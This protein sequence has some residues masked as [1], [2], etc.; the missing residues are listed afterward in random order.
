[1]NVSQ[2]AT[3]FPD[4]TAFA[5]NAV[6]FMAA[7]AAIIAGAWKAVKEVRGAVT[8]TT[9]SDNG[10]QTRVASAVL[11]ETTSMNM[12]TTSNKEVV[13]AN[14]HLCECLQQHGEKMLHLAHQIERLRD[15]MP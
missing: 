11:M 13:E 15:K 2:A 14:N 12:L 8:E 9:K 1:M 6:L 3:H 7:V 10:Q 5:A 4:V